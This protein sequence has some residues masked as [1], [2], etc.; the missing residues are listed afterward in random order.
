[1]MTADDFDLHDLSSNKTNGG[2]I[3]AQ[4][5]AINI[6]RRWSDVMVPYCAAPLI[7]MRAFNDLR[8][9]FTDVLQQVD[10]IPSDLVAM[11]GRPATYA[12]HYNGLGRT[13]DEKIEVMKQNHEWKIAL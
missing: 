9:N 8:K 2:L 7:D 11:G 1:M 6:L 12:G 5:S 13:I 3:F 4:P 10:L